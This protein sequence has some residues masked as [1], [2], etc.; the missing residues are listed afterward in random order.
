MYG[1]RSF[2]RFSEA[3]VDD[4]FELYT[5]TPFIVFAVFMTLGMLTLYLLSRVFLLVTELGRD[6]DAPVSGPES[7]P[8]LVVDE[9]DGTRLA[10]SADP[11]V[12]ASSAPAH[13]NLS[14]QDPQATRNSSRSYPILSGTPCIE[15]IF[16]YVRTIPLPSRLWFLAVS[17]STI[18]GALSSCNLLMTK[19]MCVSIANSLVCVYALCVPRA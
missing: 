18:G 9:D 5:K 13:Q 6:A 12:S 2:L 11:L 15:E 3:A 19:S 10:G 14:L 4:L 7:E 17:Y 16:A 8:V 1:C